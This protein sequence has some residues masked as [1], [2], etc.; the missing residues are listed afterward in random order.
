[1]NSKE[2]K[3]FR[4]VVFSDTHGSFRHMISASL[5]FPIPTAASAI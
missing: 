2:K 1:M 3:N 5:Y 4:I